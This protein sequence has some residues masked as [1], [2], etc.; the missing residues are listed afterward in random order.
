MAQSRR[1]VRH[2]IKGSATFINGGTLVDGKGVAE[3]EMRGS[4]LRTL[5]VGDL[6]VVPT[7]TPYCNYTVKVR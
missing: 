1:P 2:P 3:N 7:G 5:V 4:A 6:I